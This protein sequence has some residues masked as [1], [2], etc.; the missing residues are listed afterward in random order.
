MTQKELTNVFK[1]IVKNVIC[2]STM[3]IM[4]QMPIHKIL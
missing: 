3:T 1:N 2:L 4:K